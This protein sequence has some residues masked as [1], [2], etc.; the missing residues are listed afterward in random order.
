[1]YAVQVL[2]HFSKPQFH[3]GLN[4]QHRVNVQC[5][6]NNGL[7]KNIFNQTEPLTDPHATQ[8]IP[9]VSCGQRSQ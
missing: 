4:K 3:N 7:Q 1:M 8:I 2:K 5:L 9:A 6:S